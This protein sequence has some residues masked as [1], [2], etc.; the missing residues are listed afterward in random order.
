MIDHIGFAVSNLQRSKAFY[1]NALRPLGI[2]V[3]MEVSAEDTGGDAH[4]GFGKD[5][6]AFFWIGGG[7]K[8]KG[9]THVA[10]AAL[11]RAD[12]NS[13]YHAALAAGGL[14]NGPPGL[15]PHYHPN[16]YAAFVLDPD[17]NNIEAAC[18]Q[19]E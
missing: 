13:F 9:G 14:D 8:P 4:A 3:I 12:V 10:F 16:H 19:P 7:A 18:R 2:S 5:D 6:E 1:V 11:T 15:R 17:G